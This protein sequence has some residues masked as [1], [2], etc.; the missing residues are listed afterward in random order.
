MS[1]KWNRENLDQSPNSNG[2][3]SHSEFQNRAR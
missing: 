2:R 3:I 1:M